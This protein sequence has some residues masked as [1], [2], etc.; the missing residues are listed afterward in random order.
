LLFRAV[1][2]AAFAQLLAGKVD[3]KAR[4]YHRL[5]DAIVALGWSDHKKEI[6]QLWKECVKE[7]SKTREEIANLRV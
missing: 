5:Q 1:T 4:M 2:R 6:I 3:R 7:S